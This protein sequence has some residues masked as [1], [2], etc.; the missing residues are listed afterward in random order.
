MESTQGVNPLSH[1]GLSMWYHP[2]YTGGIHP[3]ARFPRDR[4]I[5]VLERLTPFISK[6]EE[7]ADLEASIRISNPKPIKRE[8]LL[9]AHDAEYV[10][11]FLAGSLT[12]KEIRRIGLTPWTDDMIQRTL[13]LMGGAV[14]ATEH[15]VQFGGI[16]ANMAGG[17]HHAHRAF[18]SGYCV[19]NDLA[20]SALHALNNLNVGRVAVLDL[21]VH[22]GD[23]TATALQHV[24]EALTVS[25]HCDVNFPF[26]KSI[27]DHDLPLAAES[28]DML[29]LEAV[30][31]ALDLCF[32]HQP[33]L[34]LF[35][36]GVDALT[37]DALGK[38]NVSRLGMKQRNDM[39]F[40]RAT[41]LKVPVVVFM[42]GGYA[43]PLDHTIDAFEDLF[44]QAAQ[45][46][47]GQGSTPPHVR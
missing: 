16:S 38:L 11:R 1:S 47:M 19:F 6:S 32:N 15:A 43:K 29:Y 46:S 10:D 20:V 7:P 33:E 45:W 37:T 4:Y 14:E 13:L 25:V 41:K 44:T 42:G 26:R 8:H 39:V 35:Q 30:E 27:S 5:R 34:L 23:G 40:E 18:G 28:G 2:L 24:Q 31:E 36:A 9:L 3:D 12:E 22:Q 21:D 17:T